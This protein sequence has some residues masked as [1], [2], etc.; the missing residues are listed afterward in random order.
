MSYVGRHQPVTSKTLSRWILATM[1]ASGI[2]TSVWSAHASKAAA[3]SYQG[4]QLSC[5]DLMKLAD[6]SLT[7]G[8][9]HKFYQR[10]A[11]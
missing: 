9:Y 8:V 4:K 6:W 3:A 1:H 5:T 11:V 10:Y 7:S 2:D